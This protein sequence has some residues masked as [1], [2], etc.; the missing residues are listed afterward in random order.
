EELARG[1]M[2]MLLVTHEMEF[3]RRVADLTVFMH[4]GKVW[5][6]RPSKEFFADPQTPEAR[7]FI[8][9]GALK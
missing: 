4:Q 1:G 3:A 6:A 9:A 2:T 7:Q 8:G 5:E